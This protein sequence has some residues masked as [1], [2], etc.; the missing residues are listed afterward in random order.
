ML[1][2]ETT[3]DRPNS[4]LTYNSREHRQI[5]NGAFRWPS[6]RLSTIM[7]IQAYRRGA[8]HYDKGSTKSE[9]PF[10]LPVTKTAGNSRIQPAVVF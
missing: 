9:R 2:Q 7:I 10:T 1:C 4:I 8:L 6:A 5:R 3:N